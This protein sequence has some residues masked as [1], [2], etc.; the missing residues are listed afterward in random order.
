MGRVGAYAED[1]REARL[2]QQVED[3]ADAEGVT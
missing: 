3:I 2:R 1:G